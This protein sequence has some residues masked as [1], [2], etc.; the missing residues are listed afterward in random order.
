MYFA[1]KVVLMVFAFGIIYALP[2]HNRIAKKIPPTQYGLNILRN[3]TPEDSI[4]M[5][6]DLL[7]ILEVKKKTEINTNKGNSMATMCG[8]KPI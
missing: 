6:S 2:Y 7:A 3:P 8:I 1:S 4:A 5:N